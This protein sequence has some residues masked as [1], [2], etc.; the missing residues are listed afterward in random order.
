MKMIILIS[1]RARIR[2]TLGGYILYEL[3]V[4][5][6]HLITILLDWY[7]TQIH[8]PLDS[9]SNPP[10]IQAG[11]YPWYLF[12]TLFTNIVINSIL[13][14]QYG[15]CRT[16]QPSIWKQS[17]LVGWNIFLLILGTVNT[18]AGKDDDVMIGWLFFLMAILF[19]G[20]L[21]VHS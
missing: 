14:I 3:A 9:G 1:D 17:F 19:S 20:H 21:C 12:L 18:L 7:L 5:G 11:D 4:C 2:W 8:S 15:T 6:N 10:G 16:M 13:V